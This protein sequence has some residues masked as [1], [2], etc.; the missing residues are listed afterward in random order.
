M[1]K[2]VEQMRDFKFQ[3]TK[4]E[5]LILNKG[6]RV[7]FIPKFHCELNPIE[8]VWCHAKIYTRTHCD[9]TFAGLENTIDLV[10]DSVTVDLIRK[11]LRKVMEYHR[12]YR[13][14]NII[15]SDMKKIMKQ[16]KS[17]RR[18]SE[19]ALETVESTDS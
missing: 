10:L 19:A 12:A 17:H 16:Y 6:H 18:V 14:G 7:M 9:Y 5:E 1:I 4:V 2:I 11:F 8:C 13:E 3:R 15:G